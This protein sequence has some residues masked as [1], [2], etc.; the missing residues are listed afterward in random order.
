MAKWTF[1][2]IATRR[3]FDVNMDADVPA[4]AKVWIAAMWFSTRGEL[5]TPSTAQSV[6][7]GDGMSKLRM[8][9]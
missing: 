9:A 4:G 3:T 1:R 7:V 5:S 8:A 2:G 6:R